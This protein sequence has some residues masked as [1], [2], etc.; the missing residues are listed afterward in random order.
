MKGYYEF[1]LA[2]KLCDDIYSIYEDG[3]SD[4]YNGN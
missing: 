3:Y 4:G 2:K 1:E